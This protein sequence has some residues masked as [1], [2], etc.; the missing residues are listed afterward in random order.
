M[1]V[2]VAKIDRAKLA[3]LPESDRVLLLLLAHASNELNVL[4]KLILMMRKT[5]PPSQIIDHVEA[6]QTFILMRLL[7]GK[8]HEAWELF[9]TRVQSNRAIST[10]LLPKMRPPAA[11]ALT[12]LK[13]HFGAGSPL[14]AIR[15][16]VSFHYSDKEN[17]TEANFQQLAATE[18][19]QF[20]LTQTVGNSFYHAAEL[21][22][23][24]SAINLVK[25]PPASAGDTS[26]PEA[27]A[28]GVLCGEIIDVSRHMTELF[29]ELVG[30]LGEDVVDSV[31]TEQIPDG[32]KLST[33]ELPYFFDENDQLPG[34]S[35]P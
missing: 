22:V 19:L 4:Q 24:L 25:A 2:H 7:I 13:Q 32:P 14:T 20:Y 30:M 5:D 11:A 1:D 34:S 10:N 6:G 33:F 9:R 16:K 35:N 3:A 29:G 23:Q 8:L 27:R 12:A 26:S 28:F 21:V 18:P 15:N 17:L 31:S